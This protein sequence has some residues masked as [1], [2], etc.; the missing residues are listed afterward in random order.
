MLPFKSRPQ[1]AIGRVSGSYEYR[2][3]L[4]DAHHTRRV[5]WLRTDI[6][7]TSFGQ[8][9]L[10]SLGAFMTVCQIQRNNA[11]ERVHAILEGK[12][13]PGVIGLGKPGADDAR[14]ID[15]PIDIGQLS[16]DQI[17]AHIQQRFRGHDLARLVNAV[18]QAEGYVSQLSPLGPD[19]GVGILAGRGSLGFEGPRLCVQV[20]SS[21]SPADVTVFRAL[22]GTMATFKADQGLLAELGRVQ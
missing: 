8:D 13:D 11:E 3:D 4:G 6:P 5:E 15:V 18:L 10:Y 9:L 17:I 7:R 1:I 2:T 21:E 12:T 19:G 20:K 14:D 22:Q 16:Q